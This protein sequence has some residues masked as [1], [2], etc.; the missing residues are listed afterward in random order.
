MAYE[1]K[2]PLN[3]NFQNYGYAWRM[4]LTPNQEKMIYHNGWWHGNNAVFA[5]L[6]KD[7]ITI[8]ILGNKTNGNI[9]RGR[10]LFSIFTGKEDTTNLEQ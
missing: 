7:P 8:I 5:R 1:P 3:E 10:Q 4:T 2:S 6:L 9:Y